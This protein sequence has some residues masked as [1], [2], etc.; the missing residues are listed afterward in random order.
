MLKV[1]TGVVVYRDSKITTVAVFISKNQ[2]NLLYKSIRIKIAT[3]SVFKI[4][5][6]FYKK[7][8]ISSDFQ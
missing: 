5:G 2:F 4:E 3:R 6:W 8:Q 7:M 1:G